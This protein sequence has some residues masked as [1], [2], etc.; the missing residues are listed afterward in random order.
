MILFGV[1]RKGLVRVEFAKPLK[2]TVLQ[3]GWLRS[4]WLP[5][6]REFVFAPDGSSIEAVGGLGGETVR[7]KIRD[8]EA[9]FLN[10]VDEFGSLSESKLKEMLVRLIRSVQQTMK[11]FA[12]KLTAAY[13]QEIVD[14]AWQQVSET[15]TL[16]V[17]GENLEWAMLD[18]DFEKKITE[19]M[20][21]R[22]VVAPAWYGAYLAH[23]TAATSGAEAGTAAPFTLPGSEFA[24]NIVTS[25]ESSANNIVR[26]VTSFSGG[27]TKVTNPPPLPPPRSGGSRGGGSGGCAC[28][29]ACAG[30]ACAGG[31][32]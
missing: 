9:D 25:F 32:R 16:D 8:Y 29:C 5:G 26:D 3:K 7:P 31:G 20:E 14:K 27:V 15:E 4:D 17:L 23:R 13:Y 12:A 2:L 28:A 6:T 18:N 11:G 24:H 30:C 22:P 10:A 21:E 19:T 1:V